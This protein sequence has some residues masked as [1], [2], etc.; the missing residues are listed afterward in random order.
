MAQGPNNISHIKKHGCIRKKEG[1]D[2]DIGPRRGPSLV[3]GG[4]GGQ[5]PLTQPSLSIF[6]DSLSLCT[7]KNQIAFC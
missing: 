1:V 7:N 3:Q 2:S 5:L 4:G 6:A